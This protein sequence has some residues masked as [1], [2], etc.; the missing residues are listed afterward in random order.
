MT[1]LNLIKKI[2]FDDTTVK[3]YIELWKQECK[4]EY[5]IYEID[6]E[7]AEAY[8]KTFQYTISDTE[9]RLVNMKKNA[10]KRSMEIKK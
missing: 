5:R 6:S 8:D 7:F 2:N 1:G 10:M 4:A 9:K 3:G